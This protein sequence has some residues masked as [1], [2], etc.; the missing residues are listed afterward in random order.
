MP[1]T[2]ATKL[3]TNEQG[4]VVG[5]STKTIKNSLK[6]SSHSFLKLKLKGKLHSWFE[7]PASTMFLNLGPFAKLVKYLEDIAEQGP[8][9]KVNKGVILSSGGF[10]F[11]HDMVKQHAPSYLKKNFYPIGTLGDNGSG[12]RLGEVMRS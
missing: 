2:W 12:I 5:F 10:S 9:I 7:K 6:G 3:I 8:N 11:S 1:H 4:D